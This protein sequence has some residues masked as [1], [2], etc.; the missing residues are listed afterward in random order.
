MPHYT[1]PHPIKQRVNSLTEVGASLSPYEASLTLA[2]WLVARLKPSSGWIDM[3]LYKIDLQ[4]SAH[5]RMPL[6]H[7]EISTRVCAWQHIKNVPPESLGRHM[8][9]ICNARECRSCVCSLFD[10]SGVA[11]LLPVKMDDVFGL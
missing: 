1:G 11:L 9:S 6:H 2:L 10:L 5:R 8:E 4:L 3:D 7:S